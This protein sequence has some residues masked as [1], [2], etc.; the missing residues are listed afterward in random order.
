M[1]ATDLKCIF[2]KFYF[3][4]ASPGLIEFQPDLPVLHCTYLFFKA[5]S[6][7]LP[8][9]NLRLPAL[10]TFIFHV[11]WLQKLFW[12]RFERI[13]PNIYPFLYNFQIKILS[14]NYTCVMS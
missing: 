4:Y 9:M 2:L 5:V 12:F 10:H 6:K 13:I 7:V 8:R 14:L 3:I 11:L 1:R